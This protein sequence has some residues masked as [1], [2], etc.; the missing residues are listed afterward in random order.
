MAYGQTFEQRVLIDAGGN[1]T[2][3]EAPDDH[4]KSRLY[5][6]IGFV[7]LAFLFSFIF[8]GVLFAVNS[9]RIH[10]SKSRN[11]LLGLFAVTGAPLIAAVLL[12][13]NKTT[14]SASI[15]FVGLN[16][17]VGGLL[18][19]IQMPRFREYKTTGARSRPLLYPI[20]IAIGALAIL[21]SPTIISD[22]VASSE[23]TTSQYDDR[24]NGILYD[25]S[26]GVDEVQ[27]IA[28]QLRDASVFRD[29]SSFH[30]RLQNE[31]GQ[32]LLS[33]PFKQNALGKSDTNDFV[34]QLADYINRNGALK[35]T[36][37][38]KPVP[39]EE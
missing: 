2:K 13:S 37:R 3:V 38:I 17:A 4:K 29:D 22:I 16:L 33:I 7:P 39:G 20:L 19:S 30:F 36:L 14:V 10:G 35:K 31:E 28:V 32:Y 34:N 23:P 21:A 11:L 25:A 12:F 18:Y 8:P 15:G 6:P 24:T 27:R 26:I 5:N 9:G 1:M